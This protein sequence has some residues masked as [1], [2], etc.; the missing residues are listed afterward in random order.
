MN[1]PHGIYI[2]TAK[3]YPILNTPPPQPTNHHKST[4]HVLG[5][6]KMIVFDWLTPHPR[7]THDPQKSLRGFVKTT[8]CFTD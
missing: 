7:V 8:V 2:Q 3:F 6:F 4:G 5:F 1:D